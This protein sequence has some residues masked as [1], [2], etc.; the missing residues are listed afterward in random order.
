MLFRSPRRNGEVQEVHCECHTLRCFYPYR[1]FKLKNAKHLELL[2]VHV[3][4]C[5]LC[6]TSE[7]YADSWHGAV[8]ALLLFQR[9]FVPCPDHACDT[10]AQ[11]TACLSHEKTLE[12]F[13]REQVHREQRLPVDI[14]PADNSAAIHSF[15]PGRTELGAWHAMCYAHLVR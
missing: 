10:C 6:T 14:A 5:T 4:C 12:I 1:H 11:I 13:S 8:R 2:F 15:I 9:S 7:Y 3:S